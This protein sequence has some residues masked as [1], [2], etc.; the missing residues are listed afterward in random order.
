M[1]GQT[2]HVKELHPNPFEELSERC[3]V[4]V[5]QV[6]VIDGVVL[7]TLKEIQQVR[8][9]EYEDAIVVEQFI[10]TSQTARKV[11]DVR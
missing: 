8:H 3:E 4:E 5:R 1:D 11:V 10:E 7:D 6:L 9:L 2:P